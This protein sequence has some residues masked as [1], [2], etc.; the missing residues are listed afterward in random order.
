M[1]ETGTVCFSYGGFVRFLSVLKEKFGTAGESMLFAMS[2]DF[3]RYDTKKMMES[4][5]IKGL[6]GDV[7]KI[8]EA[9]FKGVEDL[10]W[11]TNTLDHFDLIK[12]EVSVTIGN[13]GLA[14]YCEDQS[15]PQCFFLRGVLSGFLKEVTEQDF[16]PEK[17]ECEHENSIC[18]I[19]LKRR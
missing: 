16:Y 1:S 3:G 7:Q 4:E 13:Y 9:L 10:G 11:G 12:G 19:R 8:I 6:E 17:I 18:R 14:N 5:S 15:S 2:R